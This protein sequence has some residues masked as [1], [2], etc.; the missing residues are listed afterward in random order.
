[1]SHSR[2]GP[3]RRRTKTGE[4][5]E[6]EGKRA[7]KEREKREVRMMAHI[8]GSGCDEKKGEKKKKKREK[9]KLCTRGIRAMIWWHK[10]RAERL[11]YRGNGM[12]RGKGMRMRMRWDGGWGGPGVGVGVHFSQGRLGKQTTSPVPPL[13]WKVRF[14]KTM[15]R[16]SVQSSKLHPAPCPLWYPDSMCSAPPG[17]KTKKGR[18]NVK[19]AP[20]RPI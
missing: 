16:I 10:V 7:R 18:K 15:S 17:L 11:Y 20:Y 2:A 3:R 19:S 8:S 13:W 9:K 5:V 12:E 1:M 4:G 14:R 6:R